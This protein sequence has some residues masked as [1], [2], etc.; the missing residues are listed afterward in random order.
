MSARTDQ[1][2]AVN[3]A[4]KY[5]LLALPVLD[6]EGRLVGI[7]TI[8]DLIDV[9]EEEVTEDFH[10]MAAITPAE[11][12]YFETGIFRSMSRRVLW[13]ILLLF[14]GEFQAASSRCIP[15]P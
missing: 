6:N 7:V 8:D 2:E 15:A 9:L 4:Q 5:D 12:K 11:E 14:T 1:E 13:L 3:V 10:K